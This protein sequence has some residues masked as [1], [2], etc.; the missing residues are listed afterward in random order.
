M[1]FPEVLKFLNK[2]TTFVGEA[3]ATEMSNFPSPSKSVKAIAIG[4]VLV[5]VEKSVC[6]A[7]EILPE[8]LELVK[9][10]TVAAFAL[11]VTISSFPSPSISPTAIG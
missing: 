11:P 5:P 10:E 7:K 2:E 9:I 1:T 4:T 3:P 6:D 8:V